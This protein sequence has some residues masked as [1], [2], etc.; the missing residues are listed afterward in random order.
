MTQTIV[1]KKQVLDVL[2]SRRLDTANNHAF[3]YHHVGVHDNSGA[4]PRFISWMTYRTRSVGGQ[5]TDW[6]Q[7]PGGLSQLVVKDED[8]E[9]VADDVLVATSIESMHLVRC[10]CSKAISGN[11]D[12]DKKILDAWKSE[13]DGAQAVYW[14]SPRTPHQ[15]LFVDWDGMASATISQILGS[16]ERGTGA[17]TNATADDQVTEHHAKIHGGGK[18]KKKMGNVHAVDHGSLDA[19]FEPA[20]MTSYKSDGS[21]SVQASEIELLSEISSNLSCR[22]SGLQISMQDVPAGQPPQHPSIPSKYG[23]VHVDIVCFG[24]SNTSIQDFK[25]VL[26]DTLKTQADVLTKLATQNSHSYPLGSLKARH[27]VPAQL[28]PFPVTILG[29]VEHG[30]ESLEEFSQLRVH[31]HESLLLPTNRP[32]FRSVCEYDFRPRSS[33]AHSNMIQNVKVSRLVDVHLPLCSSVSSGNQSHEYLIQGS[34]EYYH[35]MQD[36][37]DDKGWGCAYRSLQTIISWCRLQHYTTVPVPDHTKIQKLLVKIGD[38]P[39]TFVGSKEWIGANE[40]CYILDEY[41]GVSSRIMHISNGAD[42]E[43][44][45]RELMMHFIEQRTPIMI[46]GGVLAYTLLGVRYDSKTGKTKFLI[47]DPH[48]IGPDDENII[49]S[50]GW[51]GWKGPELFVQNAFYNFCMPVR[52]Q[53]V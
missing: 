22:A 14:T 48:Y 30:L 28:E 8:I 23:A 29:P 25:Q 15:P 6:L 19:E 49:R 5:V 33:E 37:F 17:S 16:N 21:K 38:K 47:L 45:G 9:W 1:V 7:I 3:H 11:I 43:S 27:F 12:V 10:K 46:G 18:R 13:L 32:L 2:H 42:I 51:C 31:I 34:Y 39:S 35:Y 36:K 41:A 4:K 52:P 40:V 53:I 20:S 44:K 26:I 50:K 24:S